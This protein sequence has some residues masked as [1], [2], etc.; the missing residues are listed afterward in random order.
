MVS[1]FDFLPLVF[2]AGG[3]AALWLYLS[4]L[5]LAWKIVIVGITLPGIW[6]LC[7][8][9]FRFLAYL[10]D[11]STRRRLQNSSDAELERLLFDPSCSSLSH[12]LREM[13]NRG[14]DITRFR[15]RL[16]E[17]M[18][19]SMAE[20]GGNVNPTTKQRLCG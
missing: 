8:L 6:Y 5:C 16:A 10:L 15:S 2:A 4:S 7:R 1:S 12:V 14:Q 19:G 17:L 9:P 20:T 3:A 18:G 13:K 11:R